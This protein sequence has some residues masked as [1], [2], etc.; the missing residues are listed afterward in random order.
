MS[1]VQQCCGAPKNA[2]P[3]PGGPNFGD[4]LIWHCPPRFKI[5]AENITI[6]F[7]CLNRL[8]VKDAAVVLG[9]KFRCS[10]KKIF[11]NTRS[12]IKS[13]LRSRPPDKPFTKHV[14]KDWANFKSPPRPFR[15][16]FFLELGGRAPRLPHQ[17]NSG[18][19]VPNITNYLFVPHHAF[20][21]PILVVV[22][23]LFQDF[24]KFYSS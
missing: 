9:N 5:H 19:S 15:R 24:N 20:E 17:G 14:H 16:T 18:C 11:E 10:T 7:Q 22:R 1:L 6:H 8:N 21:F 2:S 13:L 23:I 3:R 12:I 4:A